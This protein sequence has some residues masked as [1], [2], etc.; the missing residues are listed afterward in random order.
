M[1]SMS[2][3]QVIQILETVSPQAREEIASWPRDSQATTTLSQMR[4]QQVDRLLSGPP[5][6]DTVRRA[7]TTIRGAKP[8]AR[9]I[10]HGLVLRNYGTE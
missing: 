8:G 3:E 5:L 6:P 9:I 2:D 1:L 10:S 7:A 4:Q